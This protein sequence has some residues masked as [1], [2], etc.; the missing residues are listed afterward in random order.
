MGYLAA[1]YDLKQNAV[2]R[3]RLGV[4]AQGSIRAKLHNDYLLSDGFGGVYGQGYSS[5][6]NNQ[7]FN[8]GQTNVLVLLTGRLYYVNKLIGT[9]KAHNIDGTALGHAQL[10]ILAYRLWGEKFINFLDGDFSVIVYD[11]DSHTIIAGRDQLGVKP[12]YYAR[13]NDQ[14]LFASEQRQLLAAGV[15]NTPSKTAIANYLAIS[16][17]LTG[18]NTTF[19]EHIFQVPAGHYL[20]ADSQNIR[21]QKYWELDPNRTLDTHDEAELAEQLREIM[22][23]SVA[24]RIPDRPPY[25]CALS[26]GFDSS[27][28]AGL[29]RQIL[30]ERG[31]HQPL[32]TFSFELRDDAADEHDLIKS[33]AQKVNSRHT[34]IY[35]DK[36]NVF[37]VLPAMI[38]SMEHPTYDMGLL[39]LWRKKEIAAQHQVYT[40]L[41]GLGGDE[42]FMGRYYYFAD[43][44]KSGRWLELFSEVKSLYP[45]DKSTG[46]RTSLGFLLKAYLVSP[47]IPESF[48]SLIRGNFMGD[49]LIKPWISTDLAKSTHLRERLLEGPQ[50]LYKD[51]YRQECFETFLYIMV[52]ITLPIHQSLGAAHN[53]DTRFP[54]L[55]K[56]LV[57]FMF[58]APRE[59]KIRKGSSRILQRKAMQGIL[60]ESVTKEHLKKNVNPVLWQQQRAN[61]ILELEKLFSSHDLVSYEYL[62]KSAVSTLY[63]NYLNGT[64]ASIGG[65]ILWYVLNLETWLRA[66]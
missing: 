31:D 34:H 56:Y 36:D 48:K 61:F 50:L 58:A 44:F 6:E 41:S 62:D 54:L 26:G 60:P 37:D 46:K 9:L 49:K 27:S 64:G 10:I 42:V 52:N 28:V 17:T 33:V 15:N 59:V 21:L 20:I 40:M 12:L 13:F 55:D 47:L 65:H 45:I 14:M 4:M 30:N 35:V 32:D 43:L 5:R 51:A 63:K 1:I 66:H 23:I 53:V 22:R 7:I 24:E 2:D 29:Y 38:N 25:G 57:E 11:G 8:D 18:G 16:H 39:Y 3:E 19:Y